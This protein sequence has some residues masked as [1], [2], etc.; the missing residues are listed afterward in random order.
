[1]LIGKAV[2]SRVKNV[3][4]AQRELAALERQRAELQAQ[5]DSLTAPRAEPSASM[6]V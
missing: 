6:K 4:Q 5:L 2:P 1:L 3:E